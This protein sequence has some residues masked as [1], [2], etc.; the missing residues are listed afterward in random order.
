VAFNKAPR[1]FGTVS[2][3]KVTSIP[4]PSSAF[5]PASS[6]LPLHASPTPLATLTPPPFTASGVHV[7][8]KANTDQ[9]CPVLSAANTPWQSPHSASLS[10]RAPEVTE[11][12][13]SGSRENQGD[14]NQQ[15]G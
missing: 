3:S 7:N 9:R 5:M 15:N 4:S 10:E 2:S 13:Q 11:G 14:S 12:Q 6:S 1:P 8:V